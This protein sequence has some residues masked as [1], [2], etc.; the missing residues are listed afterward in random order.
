MPS[1]K[2]RSD[3]LKKRLADNVKKCKSVTAFFRYTIISCYN[4][5][6][7][8]STEGSGGIYKFNNST[9]HHNSA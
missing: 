9:E 5:V 8:G 4:F 3:K 2:C 1:N 6:T 7:I